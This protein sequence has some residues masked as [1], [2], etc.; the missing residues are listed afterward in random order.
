MKRLAVLFVLLIGRFYAAETKPPSD[1]FT[2]IDSTM[3]TLER[4]TGWKAKHKVQAEWISREKLHNFVEARLKEEVKPEDIR[5][6]QLT[7]RMFGL[8]PEGFDLRKTTVDL[9]TEQA[10]AFYD[11]N[12]KKLFVLDTEDD[13]TERRI[14]LAHELAH[15]LADQRFS[16]KKYMNAGITSDDASTARQAVV[17]GQATWLMWAF[18]AARDGKVAGVPSA[19]ADMASKVADSSQDQFPVLSGAPLY[20]RESMMFPYTKGLTFQDALFKRDGQKSFS[21][22]F[23]HPPAST[24]QILHPDVYEKGTKPSDVDLPRIAERKKYREVAEGSVGELDHHT[25]LSQYIDEK[26]ADTVAPLWRGGDFRL[27]ETKGKNRQ[28]LL[29]YGSMW[30]SPATATRFMKLYKKILAGKWKHL[31]LEHE[32]ADELSGTGDYGPFRVWRKDNVV[33][34]LEGGLH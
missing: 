1:L 9:V 25:L 31:K 7:L 11:Y 20:M 12:R 27:Y 30:D 10:A 24:Q 2:Q 17:E 22:V 28:P 19:L 33:Y 3:D 13:E 23:V 32:T 8:I 15:A 14:T 6:E 21:E 34:S 26:T 4:I 5:I 16:L 18:L 29:S